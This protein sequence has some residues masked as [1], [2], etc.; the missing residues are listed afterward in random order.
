MKKT[1]LLSV[2]FILSFQFFCHAQWLEK[3][4]NGYF[5]LSA[6]SLEADQHYTN[7]GKIDPNATR[8][9]FNLNLYGKYGLSDNWDIIA[10]IPFYVK[11]Y[12]NHQ[13]S[14]ITN[15]TLINGEEFNSFGDMDLGIEYR[16]FK[17]SKYAFSTTLTLGIPAGNS[18]GG[19]DGSY[20]TGDGEFNQL[21]RFNAGTSFSLFKHSFYAKSHIGFNNKTKNYSDEIR[22]GLEV[23]TGFFDSRL[24]LLLRSNMVKSLKNGSLNASNSN[25][26]IFANNVEYI[27]I[28]GEV[29]WKLTKKIGIGLGYSSAI[30]GKVI[31]AA[32]SYNAGIFYLLK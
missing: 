32:P 24:L 23:G 22:A 8:G 18:K 31:Y 28:G 13:V 29:A 15:E 19:S 30:S 5:K 12:Q 1:I 2:L 27:S 7:S 17:K 10:Y 26:S 14:Q 11:S 16:L 20:Q 21:L 3:K 25:G 4:G 9:V 6:W